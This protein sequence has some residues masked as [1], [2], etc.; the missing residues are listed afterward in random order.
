MSRLIVA[1]AL[2][3]VCLSAGAAGNIYKWTDKDGVVH[4]GSE[5]PAEQVNSER[6]KVSAAPSDVGAA[7]TA[8]N[9]V[10]AKPAGS[11]LAEQFVE[12]CGIARKNLDSFRSEGAVALKNA[13][14][15][16]GAELDAE[17]RAAQIKTA[18]E[19]V[20]LYCK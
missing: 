13:D 10:A 3:L 1:L 11:P 5:P 14:G 12:N 9:T 7:A 2:A 19:Q 8:G 20:A 18:E 15:T 6:I 16:V 17:Q 4:Y